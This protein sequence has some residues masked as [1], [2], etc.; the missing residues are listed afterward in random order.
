[1][2]MDNETEKIDPDVERMLKSITLEE[3][4]RVVQE[5]EELGEDTAQMRQALEEI[6]E[7][8]A[9]LARLEKEHQTAQA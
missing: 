9:H 6:E 5:F 2:T 8:E 7:V 1:M 3:L 4:R